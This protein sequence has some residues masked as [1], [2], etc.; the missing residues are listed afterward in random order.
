MDKRASEPPTFLRYQKSPPSAASKGSNRTC[1]AFGA[2]S[3]SPQMSPPAPSAPIS[4]RASSRTRRHSTMSSSSRIP[5]SKSPS[6]SCRTYYDCDEL[7]LPGTTSMAIETLICQSVVPRSV[8]HACTTPLSTCKVRYSSLR[9]QNRR[10]RGCFHG[11]G[12]ISLLL[13]LGDILLFLVI[14]E[15]S[16]ESYSGHNT[17][18]RHIRLISGN[19]QPTPYALS[20]R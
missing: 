20:T 9:L 3:A 11:L 19:G 13:A 14:S 2:T 17:G 10:S 15:E 1:S 5:G 6:G 8:G 12:T 4:P 16:E 18:S 7:L